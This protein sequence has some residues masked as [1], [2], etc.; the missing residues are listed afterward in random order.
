[1]TPQGALLRMKCLIHLRR[2][3][4]AAEESCGCHFSKDEHMHIM[5]HHRGI[6]LL[7][8]SPFWIF[9][10]QECESEELKKSFEDQ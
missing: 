1:M 6:S 8:V 9:N 10:S 5:K 3:E 2:F 4:D 7:S